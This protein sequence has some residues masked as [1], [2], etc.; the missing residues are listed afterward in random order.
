MDQQMEEAEWTP[1]PFNL[2]AGNPFSYSP[3]SISTISGTEAFNT[4]I[5]L[6]D[7]EHCVVCGEEDEVLLEHTHIVPK[8]EKKTVRPLYSLLHATI[9]QSFKT[10]IQWNE[11]RH[12]GFIPKQAKSVLHEARNGF[13][14]CKNHHTAFDAHRFFVRWVPEV[15]YRSLPFPIS[16]H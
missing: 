2:L 16:F 8:V 3:R 7:K 13:L 15:R 5:N 12:K 1:V 10:L 4:G 11:M 14:M 9:W 6:R